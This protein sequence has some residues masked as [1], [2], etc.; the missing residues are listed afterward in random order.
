VEGHY[1]PGVFTNPAWAIALL[2]N[3][4]GAPLEI[5]LQLT[6]TV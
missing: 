6:E 1:R 5:A 3:L 2:S 4:S